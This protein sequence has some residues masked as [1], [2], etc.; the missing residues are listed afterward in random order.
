MLK[1]TIPL[2]FLLLIFSSCKV[3]DTEKVSLKEKTAIRQLIQQE[4][5]EGI[6]ATKTKNIDLYMS[7]MPDD[8]IIYDESGEVIS[9][10]KQKEH[11]L[12][13]WAIID[14][15]LHISVKID[16]IQYPKKDSIV[17]YTHQKWKR[18]MFQR[19]GIKTDTILTTQKHKEIWKKTNKG[20]FGYQIIE[21][22]GD[23]FI[24]GNLH[25]AK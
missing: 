25:K 7:Q 23:V 1:R 10:Q 24:N 16:S 9:K 17:V 4:I 3:D 2:F 11:A 19:N 8:L 14:T 20:W 18:M 13:D 5:N 6:E 12:R 22:G 21:L 15:T